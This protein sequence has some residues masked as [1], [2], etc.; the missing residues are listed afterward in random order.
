MKLV[1][2]LANL[3]YGTRRDVTEMVKNGFV[4]RRDGS[5]VRDG[6]TFDHDDLLIHGKPADPPPGTVVLLHKPTGYVCSA[7]DTSRLI[8]ELLPPRFLARSPIV[9][10]IGRLD[11]DTSG[12]L[13]LTDDGKINHRL[14]SPKTHLAKV[15]DAELASDLRGDEDALFASG[16]LMLNGETEPLLAAG[17]EVLGPRQA[18]VTLY[19]GRYHQVRRMFAAVG[20]HVVA[21]HRRSIGSLELGSLEVGQWRELSFDEVAALL[22]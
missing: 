22:P 1:K 8:Y 9:A 20:N 15:Y 10:P 17:L 11:R 14:A 18:R 3:G 5:I 16:T 13:L 6:E 4:T 2:Y 19:E 7:R 12:L 21:L